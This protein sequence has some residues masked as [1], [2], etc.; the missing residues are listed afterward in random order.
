MCDKASTSGQG[1]QGVEYELRIEP[2]SHPHLL[3]A[4]VQVTCPQ[5]L[6]LVLPFWN[7]SAYSAMLYAGRIEA[8]F[9]S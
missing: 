9:P 5:V 6:C 8:A 2:G 4:S 7:K 3:E 1:D